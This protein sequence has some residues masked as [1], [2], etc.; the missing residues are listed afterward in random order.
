MDSLRGQTLRWTFTDGPVAGTLFEHTFYDDDRVEWRVLE[1][2]G[3]GQSR[4]EK[5]YA[6]MQV[7]DDVHTV[8][9]LAE[10][11]HTLTVV[12]NLATRRMFGFASN[13]NEWFPLTGTFE[14]V[15]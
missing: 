5:R 1:G 6:A 8:S 9:Y 11:G 14:V 4:K 13:N 10:S 7:T 2:P 15:R 3:K 12:L